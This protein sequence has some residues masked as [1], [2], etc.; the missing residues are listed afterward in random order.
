MGMPASELGEVTVQTTYV[1][2][3]RHCVWITP[4]KFN[5]GVMVRLAAEP[6]AATISS[7]EGSTEIEN[8]NVTVRL[9]EAAEDVANEPP[10]MSIAETVYRPGVERI[11]AVEARPYASSGTVATVLPLLAKVML[12]VGVAPEPADVADDVRITEVPGATWVEES[13]KLVSVG[14]GVMVKDA[15]LLSEAR[16]LPSP[17]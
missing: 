4:L 10:G 11:S 3:E 6:E 14:M 12:P 13:V 16:S 17:A 8:G 2:G 9:S 1:T 7:F 5:K 15:G